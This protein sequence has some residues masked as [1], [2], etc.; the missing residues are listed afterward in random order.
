MHVAEP[1]TPGPWPGVV[2]VHEALGLNDEIRAKAD[3][4]AQRGYL[5]VAPDGTEVRIRRRAGRSTLTVKSGPAHVRVE[6]ELE[7]DDRRFEALWALTEGRRIA[8]TRHLVPLG[9]GLTAE[10]DVYAEALDGLLTAEIE[11]P[12]TAASAAFVPPP[13]LGAEVTGDARYA[14]QSLALAGV[15]V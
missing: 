9:G 12:S 7:I 13:W 2:V 3:R 15:P 8:K 10:V 11:F 6:E 1:T 14:N 4:F 5:A